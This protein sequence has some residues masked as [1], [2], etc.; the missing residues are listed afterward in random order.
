MFIIKCRLW[1]RHNEQYGPEETLSA[2]FKTLE[3]AKNYKE[4]SL[5]REGVWWSAA[6]DLPPKN[7]RIYEVRRVG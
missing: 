2:R 1:D 6:F 3:R 5:K 4:R 7:I